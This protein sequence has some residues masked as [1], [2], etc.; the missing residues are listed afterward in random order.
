MISF[1]PRLLYT[2]G[3]VPV[4][5]EEEFVWPIAKE[6]CPCRKSKPAVHPYTVTISAELPRFQI[7]NG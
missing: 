7:Y 2:E 1:A 4:K 5:V 3:R 6:A